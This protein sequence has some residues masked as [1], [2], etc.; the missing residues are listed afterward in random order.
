MTE[1]SQFY[2]DLEELLEL[3]S[4]TIKG[5]EVLTDINWDSMAVVAFIA[6]ADANYGSSVHVAQL[7]QATTVADLL[8]L[9]NG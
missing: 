6:M 5:N 8:A 3:D 1:S 7:Q 9:L 2:H 4:D